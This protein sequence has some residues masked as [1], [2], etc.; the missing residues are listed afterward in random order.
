MIEKDGWKN[1][2]DIGFPPEE[3][4]FGT[5]LDEVFLSFHKWIISSEGHK[6]CHQYP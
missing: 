2:K 6:D 1:L 3:E 5:V 4:Y